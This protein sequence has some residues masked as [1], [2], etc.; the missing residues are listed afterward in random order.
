[1]KKS[2]LVISTLISLFSFSQ[3]TEK[4]NDD[5]ERVVIAAYVPRQIVNMPEE[6]R[7]LLTNKL[8]QIV[9]N[10]IKKI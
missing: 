1:M 7:T 10:M 8:N 6:A 9:T 5:K 3:N 2:F 4:K